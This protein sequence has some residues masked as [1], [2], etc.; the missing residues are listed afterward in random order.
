MPLQDFG[1][2]DLWHETRGKLLAEGSDWQFWIDWYDNVLHGDPQ[3]WLL[4]T[5]IALI[6]PLVWNKG[7]DHVN[8]LIKQIIEQH[9]LAAEAQR[10]KAE[11]EQL[12]EQLRALEQRSHNN[13]PDGLVD[14]L[15]TPVA[16][17]EISWHLGDAA[18]E[19]EKSSPSR[20]LLV[21]I[22]TALLNAAKAFAV[23]C[24]SLADTALTEGAKAFGKAGGTAF[25]ACF[26]AQNEQVQAFA[27][28]LF[29]FA[30][31]LGG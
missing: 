21:K 29:A 3:D 13:P 4:L 2:L 25:V 19:L 18:R 14:D 24:G 5:K 17:T 27:R 23:Y 7:A 16:L 22:A 12:V 6:D 20:S 10:L 31:S 30:R 8:A 15:P 11:N 28:A 1:C 9:K 26:A